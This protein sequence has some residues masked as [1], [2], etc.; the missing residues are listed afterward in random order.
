[1]KINKNFL[2]R[3]PQMPLDSITI[4][5]VNNKQIMKSPSKLLDRTKQLK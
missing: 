1:M 3:D 4:L 2:V 5:Q